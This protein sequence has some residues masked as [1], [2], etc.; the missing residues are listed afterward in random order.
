LIE[1]SWKLN[2]NE[3]EIEPKLKMIEKQV[4]HRTESPQ[5]LFHYLFIKTKLKLMSDNN[6]NDK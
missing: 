3:I 5:E 1:N 2:L 6:N 4:L